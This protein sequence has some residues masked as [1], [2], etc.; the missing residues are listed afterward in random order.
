MVG[1]T[2]GVA[3]PYDSIYNTL[4]YLEVLT[5]ESIGKF[6]SEKACSE[7]ANINNLCTQELQNYLIDKHI[8]NFWNQ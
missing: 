8:V 4:L 1:C 3:A 2:D 6:G 7:R 5:F